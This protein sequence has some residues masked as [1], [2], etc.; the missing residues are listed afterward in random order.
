MATRAAIA[1]NAMPD[2]RLDPDT[3]YQSQLHSLPLLARGKVRDNYAV[4][5]DRLLMVASGLPL[6]AVLA[7]NLVA[8]LLLATLV[9]LV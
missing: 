3:L 2:A 4:G 1:L 8:A 7:H 6:V 9:R 5:A